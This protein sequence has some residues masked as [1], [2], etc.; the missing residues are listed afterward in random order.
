MIEAAKLIY[1]L[2]PAANQKKALDLITDLTNTKNYSKESFNLKTLCQVVALL[3]EKEYFGK[4]LFIYI[5][6]NEKPFQNWINFER[7]LLEIFEI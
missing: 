1:D 5:N 2:N 4:F 3:E 7:Y 6:F